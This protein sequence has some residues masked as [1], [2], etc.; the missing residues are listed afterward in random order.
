VVLQELLN[1]IGLKH[2]TKPKRCTW[3]DDHANK[4]ISIITVL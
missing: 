1:S 4:N 2:S 3:I